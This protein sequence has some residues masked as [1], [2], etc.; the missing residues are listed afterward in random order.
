MADTT[1]TIAV[2]GATGNQGG[3]VVDA[4]L[5]AGVTVRALVRDPQ[6]EGA[7]ALARRGVHLARIDV[8]VPD[9]IT[10]ALRGAD[11][12]FFMTSPDG[13]DGT[14]G[15]TRVG[16]TLASAAADAGV[17]HV[18]FSSVGGADRG[19]GVPHFESKRRVEEHLA[20]LP[21]T[22]T[23]IRPVFFMENFAQRGIALEHGEL[24]VRKPL[25][26]GVPL[27]MIA[28][29]DIGVVAAAALQGRLQPG[30]AV[31]IAG[32]ELTGSQ[33]AAALSEYTGLPARYVP[34]PL[35]ALHGDDDATAMFR[36]FADLPAYDADFPLTRRL[37][38]GLL[39]FRAWLRAV[40]WQVPDA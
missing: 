37:S 22:A 8:S 28:V 21:V 33:I 19:S 32:D 18:V 14:E 12:F 4:L 3:A 6:S 26:D 40:E 34:I 35:T 11:A 5:D 15:E 39:D 13:P 1:G 25:P 2:F 20:R 30:S 23:L 7:L 29:R 31:E 17:G 27:Q 10:A 9:T 38:P 24:V 16:L 36:W